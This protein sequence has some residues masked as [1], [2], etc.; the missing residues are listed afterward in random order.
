M[1]NHEK[2]PC[3]EQPRR[4]DKGFIITLMKKE[5][6]LQVIH[7]PILVSENISIKSK[8]IYHYHPFRIKYDDQKEQSIPGISGG[9]IYCF[10]EIFNI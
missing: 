1:F 9:S 6:K 10:P 2:I 4:R 5:Q 7:Q 3:Q 8:S